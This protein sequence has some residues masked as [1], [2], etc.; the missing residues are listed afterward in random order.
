MNR[1]AIAAMA[2]G[3]TLRD[4]VVRGLQIR[5]NASGHSWLLYYKHEGV[6]RRPRLGAWP[7]LDVTDARRIAREWLVLIAQGKDPS[8]ERQARRAAPTVADLVARGFEYFQDREQSRLDDM[9]P[10]LIEVET[11][12]AN[13]HL[14]ERHRYG[15]FIKRHMGSKKVADVSLSDVETFVD[16]VFRRKYATPSTGAGKKTAPIAANRARAYLSKLMTLAE[17]RFAM[18]PR[19][20]NPVTGSTS[21]V[22]RKR[23]RPASPQEVRSI[24]DALASEALTH[25]V[26]VALL[27]AVLLTGA[28]PSELHGARAWQLSENVLDL[29]NHK[30]ADKTR[31][32]RTIVLPVQVMS[33]LAR[34]SRPSGNEHLWPC[35]SPR[36][37]W[38]RARTVAGCPDLT[39]R[40]LRQTFA[41]VALS[42]GASLDQIGEIFSHRSTQTTRGYAWLQDG[43]AGE[44]AQQIADTIATPRD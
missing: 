39:V 12:K 1:A 24:L 2:T 17:T 10:R 37:V 15:E 11:V 35:G 8:A 41:S 14:A 42:S 9:D 25:P 27:R 44:L 36:Y 23:R 4:T 38:N 18:R 40:D 16:A 30:T 3:E 19:G 5:R 28:R 34:L 29:D 7:D 32:R 26:E 13:K 21:K 22:E 6:Q 31:E 43:R 33:E 20:S